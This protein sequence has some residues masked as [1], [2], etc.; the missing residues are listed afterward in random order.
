MKKNEFIKKTKQLNIPDALI[1]ID[2]RLIASGMIMTRYLDEFWIVY[3]QDDHGQHDYEER[4][5][6]EESA[7]DYLYELLETKLAKYFK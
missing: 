3:H 5:R 6:S 2:G 4:F 7:Y 1:S